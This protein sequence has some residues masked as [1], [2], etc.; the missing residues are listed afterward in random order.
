[1]KSLKYTI[2][3][4]LICFYGCNPS[5]YA[6]EGLKY[7]HIKGVIIEKYKTSPGCFGEIVFKENNHFDTLK[8]ICYCVIEQEKIWDYVLPND[9]LYKNSGSFVL[10]VVR[11]GVKRSFDYPSCIQ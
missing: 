2:V 9:S 11:Q 3:A 1:M 10:T 4:W 7:L 8:Q 5:P 6:D